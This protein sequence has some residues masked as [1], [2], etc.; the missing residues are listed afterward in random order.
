MGSEAFGNPRR[1]QRCLDCDD[2]PAELIRSTRTRA[3][4]S[5]K[6]IVDTGDK[7]AG[8]ACLAPDALVAGSRRTVSVIARQELALVDPQLAVEEMQ[9]FDTGM[10]MRRI[11]RARRQAHQHADSVPFAIGRQQLALDAGCDLLPIR[12][13]PALS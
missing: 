10:G 2:R 5:A 3:R 13:G 7:N 9:F 6:G 11:T 8:A 12:L 1:C 4:A